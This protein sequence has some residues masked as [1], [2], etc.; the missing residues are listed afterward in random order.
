MSDEVR[1]NGEP[2]KVCNKHKTGVKYRDEKCPFCPGGADADL[3]KPLEAFVTK[4]EG[5]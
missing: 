3:I 4:P 1:F 2:W 5:E